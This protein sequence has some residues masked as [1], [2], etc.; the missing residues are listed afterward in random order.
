MGADGQM[1]GHERASRILL[2]LFTLWALAMVAPDLHRLFR[3]L[4]SFGFYANNDGLVTDVR[5]PF[6]DEET[7]PAFEAGLRPGDRLDLAQMRCIPVS[8]RRC[9]SAL[10]ALG[11]LRLVSTGRRAEFVLAA[12]AERPARQIE[13]V[14]T[15]RP[16]SFWVLAVLLLDQIASILVILAAAWLVWTRPGRMTWG[17]F[18]YVI[19]FNPG[20]SYEYYAL[21]QHSPAALLTQD[22]LGALAQAAGYVGFIAFALRVPR[23]ESAA[24]WRAIERAL[25]FVGILLAIL[26]MS[27][28]GNLLGFPTESVTRLGI[29]S[30]FAVSASALAILLARRKELPPQDH[31]RLRWVIWGC[32]I[33]LPALTIAE[34]GQETTLLTTLFDRIGTGEP[35][36]EEV[37]GLL[38]LVNGVLCLFVSEAVRRSRVVTV[39][40]PLRRVTILGLL[41]SVPTLF[42]HQ[43][44]EHLRE[45]IRE[46]VDLP[47]FAWIALA[48]ALLF[49]ISRVHEW[50]VHLADR[51]FN[52]A[53][54][55]AGKRLGV[56]VSNAR[57]VAEVEGH[58]VHG[59]SGALGLASASVFRQEDGS[60]RRGAECRGWDAASAQSLDP[61]DAM[62]APLRTGGPFD[63]EPEAAT[64]NNLPE[65]LMRP[66]LAV[67]L[68]DRFRCLALALYGAHSAGD[69]LNRDERAML[70]GLAQEAASVLAK[71]EHDRLC[72]RIAALESALDLAASQLAAQGSHS[73]SAHL[74][75]K[76]AAS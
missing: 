56:A 68:G 21:L 8:T 9:A 23:D 4:G 3:P 59:V 6:L 58:L 32:L 33:G 43:Q 46:S 60:F 2:A 55:Q 54:A 69:D 28:F 37:W 67:P 49:V 10:A 25:P 34:I 38:H 64:R 41:L 62:L 48:A 13:I 74:D 44:I 45:S 63:I 16:L 50:A 75:A 36:P 20:Q 35:P 57:S 29:S 19:W 61:R 31:Q 24:H 70:A 1:N 30:G 12:T 76:A 73:A 27:S 5:G 7:S 11:G 51:H 53:V 18:L 15:Q 71:L 26:L 42:L 47:S 40:I 39:A 22:I 52:R 72:R 65:G 14:A 66:V 17:F